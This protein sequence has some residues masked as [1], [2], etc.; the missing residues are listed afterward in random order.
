MTH[1]RGTDRRRAAIHPPTVASEYRLPA[2][3]FPSHARQHCVSNTASPFSLTHCLS[4]FDINMLRHYYTTGIY[5]LSLV[6]DCIISRPAITRTQPHTHTHT[7]LTLRK[8]RGRLGGRASRALPKKRKGLGFMPIDY[9]NGSLR[10]TYS[11]CT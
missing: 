6:G 9:A 1:C 11:F 10:Q 5:F 3:A 7:T 2:C 8:A 4:I